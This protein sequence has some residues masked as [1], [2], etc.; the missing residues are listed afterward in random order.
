MGCTLRQK[1]YFFDLLRCVAAIAVVV[2]HVLGPYREQ[3][4]S[5]AN[6]DWA[7]A[8]GFNSASRWAVPVFI[9][10][11]GALMLTDK[12]EF[13]LDYYLKRR[14]GK[15]LVPFLVWSV[16]YA[17][18]S[19]VSLSGF[20]GGL[21]WYTLLELPFHETYYHLGFFYYFI[22]L[23]FVIPFFRWA[24]QCADR[25]AVIAF[26]V[27]WLGI[28]T[29]FLF[30]IDG[31]WSQQLVLYSGYLLLGYC[32]FHYQ[33]PA[34]R[35]LIGLGIV[36]LVATAY[37]V[38]SA[39]FAADE[40]TVGR[41]LSYKTVNTALI[42]AM[43]FTLCQRYGEGLKGKAQQSIGFISRYSLGVYLL[44]PLFLWP[45]RAFDLYWGSP[46]LMIPF[47]T[48]VCGGLALAS[49]YLL[50]KYKLTAWLVP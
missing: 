17:W 16:F 27:L 22:P 14:L 47:W 26:T 44:H 2:I 42:A 28:T 9:M 40:Y 25:T 39:S 3:L 48:V 19:G 45:V 29:L 8:I 5:I 4:G 34:R 1:I 21:A 23:Y 6:T 30:K 24:V 12:R 41:W 38:I 32:L 18:L 35:W 46:L 20:D 15:V 33:W 50:A 10:I 31:P 43:V 13:V 36:M 49:S 11:T 7:I 37:N